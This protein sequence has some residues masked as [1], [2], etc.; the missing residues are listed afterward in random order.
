[1]YQIRYL[2]PIT[3]T[4]LESQSSSLEEAVSSIKKAKDNLYFKGYPSSSSEA[5]E[6]SKESSQNDGS[7]AEPARVTGLETET[8]YETET[9]SIEDEDYWYPYGVALW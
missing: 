9:P 5:Q 6:D 1:M 3:G 2:D 4:V 8:D 7:M